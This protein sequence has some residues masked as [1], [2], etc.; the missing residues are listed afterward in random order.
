MHKALRSF[1][2]GFKPA[3]TCIALTL[4]LWLLIN[5]ALS[6]IGTSF[7]LTVQNRP[8]PMKQLAQLVDVEDKSMRSFSS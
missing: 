4:L 1:K 2:R 8:R 6:F 3:L 5:F 7:N